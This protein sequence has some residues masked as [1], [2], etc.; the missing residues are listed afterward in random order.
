M[1]IQVT[2]IVDKDD[3]VIIYFSCEYGNAF[4]MWMDRNLPKIKEYLVEFDMDESF[5]FGENI[6]ISTKEE[7]T[8]FT[9]MKQNIHMRGKLA[10]YPHD[11]FRLRIGD[12]ETLLDITGKLPL[13]NSWV[14][15]TTIELKVYDTHVL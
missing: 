14:E 6:H 1:R 5:V 12:S 2:R 15:L 10:V 4:G 3:T 9:D 8:I 13:H 7:F 11:D